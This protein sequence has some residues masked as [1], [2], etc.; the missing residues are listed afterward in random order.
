MTTEK[1]D[2]YVSFEGID[3]DGKSK[4]LLSYIEQYLA[5]P[6]HESPWLDYFRQKLR[7]REALGQDELYFVGS[8]IN[9]MRSLF[10]EYNDNEAL[11]L[12]QQVEEECC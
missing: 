5:S 10:E 12:L 11:V 4:R 1:T 2:R 7:D 6:P 3:C 8:Q 9:P